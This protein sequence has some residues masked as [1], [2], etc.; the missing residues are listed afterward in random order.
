MRWSNRSRSR[1]KS[2]LNIM[3]PP[4]DPRLP[5]DMRC[6]AWNPRPSRDRLRPHGTR[7]PSRS[8]KKN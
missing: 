7:D 2:Y 8:K 1:L 3:C 6:Y 5:P 4:E